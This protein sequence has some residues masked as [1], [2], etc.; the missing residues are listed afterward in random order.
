M[1]SNHS[2]ALPKEPAGTQDARQQMNQM[3]QEIRRTI[4]TQ[5]QMLLDMRQ[6]IVALQKQ[7]AQ[8]FHIL[9]ENGIGHH[10]H[11]AGPATVVVKFEVVDEQ[12]PFE[13]PTIQH[14]VLQRVV[15]GEEGDLPMPMTVDDIIDGELQKRAISFTDP[16]QE[17]ILLD[18]FSEALADHT[19]DMD[20]AHGTVF[21][22]R[23]RAY[24]ISEQPIN[25]HSVPV[26]AE[27][28]EH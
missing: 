27:N 11:Q 26:E 28:H 13:T 25:E 5:T 3:F 22:I 16:E 12:T 7:N 19:R 23:A 17:R 14:D 4:H 9:E 18:R 20:V 8:L 6:E 15:Y 21:Y 2:P 1:S 24:T 10:H